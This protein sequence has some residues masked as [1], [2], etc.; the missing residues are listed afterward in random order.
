MLLIRFNNETHNAIR[1]ARRTF[2]FRQTNQ[3]ILSKHKFEL[4]FSSQ[5]INYMPNS[6]FC[7]CNMKCNKSEKDM[8]EHQKYTNFALTL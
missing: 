5:L 6:G 2:G 7:I 8:S 3:F 4:A 1:F